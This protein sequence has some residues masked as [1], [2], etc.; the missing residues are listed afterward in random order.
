MP[1]N[2]GHYFDSHVK[3]R[4]NPKHKKE[5]DVLTRRLCFACGLLEKSNIDM[6]K[7]LNEW[8]YEH[9][10]QDEKLMAEAKRRKE[11]ESAESRRKKYLADVKKRV[12][13]QMTDDEKE[14]LGI[15]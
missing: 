2:G 6:G 14:A 1:C 8:H 9:K 10:L 12:L 3:Y 5:I 11:E 15:K 7:E 4:D 13:T